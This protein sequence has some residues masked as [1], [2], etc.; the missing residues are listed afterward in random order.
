MA[1]K[2]KK[3]ST[4]WKKLLIIL[5]LVALVV[6]YVW[7]FVLPELKADATVTY[8]GYTASR[9]TI[10]NSMDFSGSISV[11]N[12]ET[13][14]AE[15]NGTVRQIYVSEEQAVKEG[16]KLIRLS[17][18]ETLKANFDGH[19]NQLNVENGD[20][21]SM[22][23]GLIQIVDFANMQVTF[24][25]DEYDIANIRV[26]Q[27]CRVNVTALDTTFDS[28]I[29]HI[30]R[31]PS[32]SQGTAYYTVTADFVVTENVLP[33]MQVTVV[34]PQ[35][36]AVNAVL[37]SKSALS[38]DDTNSAYVFKKDESGNMVTEPVEIGVDNDNYVEVLSGVTEGE[39]VYAVKKTETLTG[40]AAMF[41]SIP[42][43][44]QTMP[45]GN[46]TMPGMNSPDWQNR[47]NGGDRQFSRDGGNFSNMGGGRP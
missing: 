39:T 22:G 38:F 27:E 11:I 24:R 8:D 32:N 46:Q 41:S 15:G 25:V 6:G 37:L 30:N 14:S 12:Y 29:S 42:M 18:G 33:G 13:L 16:D 3:K 2:T 47:Q 45:M 20:S 40:W 9:G 26:G 10:S 1:Q 7:F 21:V 23:Q 43:G 5:L 34:I 44:N 17:T 31:I 36:E 28:A 19:V 4:W 35:E